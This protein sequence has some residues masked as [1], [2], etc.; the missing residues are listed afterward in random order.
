MIAGIFRIVGSDR[1]EYC[2]GNILC[3]ERYLSNNKIL[4]S[5]YDGDIQDYIETN[6]CKLNWDNEESEHNN[7]KDIIMPKLLFKG[8][9]EEGFYPRMSR[10]LKSQ[11][12]E[13]I[14]KN[15]FVNSKHSLIDYEIVK[16][17]YIDFVDENGENKRKLN[18]HR[19]KYWDNEK[20]EDFFLACIEGLVPKHEILRQLNVIEGYQVSHQDYV[21]EIER[22]LGIAE[23]YINQTKYFLQ[24]GGAFEEELPKSHKYRSVQESNLFIFIKNAMGNEEKISKEIISKVDSLWDFA[25]VPPNLRQ[26]IDKAIMKKRDGNLNEAFKYYEEFFKHNQTWYMFYYGLAKL[27]CLL[28]EYQ[29]GFTCIKICTYLYPEMSGGAGYRTDHNLSY[30]YEQMYSLALKNEENESYLKSLGRPLN[31]VRIIK[32]SGKTHYTDP[33]FK[34]ESVYKIDNK[35]N[36]GFGNIND[37]TT[38]KSKKRRNRKKDNI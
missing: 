7:I 23:G 34:I 21:K 14:L 33:L 31:T 11:Y 20:G 1:I 19:L 12:P 2:G 24:K 26:V 10:K 9:I 22:Q 37:L 35:K 38:S 3:L 18:D 30:H 25:Q 5:G 8:H 15:L 6:I 32:P 29:M 17:T 36:K 4:L 13:T 28:R 16:T 27:L